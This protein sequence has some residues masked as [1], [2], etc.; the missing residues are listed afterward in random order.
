MEGTCTATALVSTVPISFLGG[1]ST[2]DGTINVKN[3]DIPGQCVKGRVL[4]FPQ[5][6][7][8]T[9]GS[10]VLY[11]LSKKGLAPGAIIVQEADAVIAVG[12]VIGNVPMIDR[13]DIA[14]IRTGDT[15][16]VD[17]ERGTATILKRAAS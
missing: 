2:E 17:G 15:V 16:Q 5:H 11:S 7:G 12:A 3:K 4:V 8:S 13:V 10:Y 14:Q 6:V 1:V 9:V